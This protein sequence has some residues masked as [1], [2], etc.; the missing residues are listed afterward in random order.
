MNI[1]V[2]DHH[3]VLAAV[4]QCDK[5]I[6]KMC[7]ETAQMLCTALRVNGFEAQYKRAHVNHPFTKW[8][9][10][11]RSNFEWLVAHGIELCNEF[12]RRFGK[13]HK[14]LEVIRNCSAHSDIIP[15][16]DMTEFA[17]AMP[18]E[19]K[20]SCPVLSYRTYYLKEKKYFAQWKKGTDAPFWWSQSTE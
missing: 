4:Y 19:Y 5:H 14:C 11:T 7:L 8:T 16:G 18:V 10:E 20:Q 2:L 17:L 1:F 12:E 15:A 9:R 6:P 13:K 3:P